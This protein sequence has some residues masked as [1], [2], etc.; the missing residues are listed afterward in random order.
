M[1]T[2]TLQH[3]CAVIIIVT[4]K[5]ELSLWSKN[6]DIQNKQNLFDNIRPLH[7]AVRVG[8]YSVSWWSS[9]W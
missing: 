3:V 4:V 2:Y 7:Y 9:S 1:T 6:K 8:S 5:Y